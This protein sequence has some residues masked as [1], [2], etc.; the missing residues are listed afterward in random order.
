MFLSRA[1][2]I[3][4]NSL[5]GEKCNNKG[6]PLLFQ[7]ILRKIFLGKISSK[8][9]RI[10]YFKGNHSFGTYGKI[11]RKINIS[12]L[13]IGTR[14]AR[15]TREHRKILKSHRMFQQ[16]PSPAILV[17]TR[18]SLSMILTVHRATYKNPNS[19]IYVKFVP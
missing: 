5:T 10:L 14:M 15:K 1:A 18:I 4:V 8:V 7:K 12:C 6:L 3:G 16:I 11:F 9:L 13:L 19:L 17:E 2:I